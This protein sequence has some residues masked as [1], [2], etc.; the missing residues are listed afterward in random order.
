MIEHVATRHNRLSDAAPLVSAGLV[1]LVAVTVVGIGLE[2][3][4]SN[5][6]TSGY[7]PGSIAISAVYV[8]CVV[9][10]PGYSGR[11]LG[12]RSHWGVRRSLTFAAK[13][14]LALQLLWVPIT[15]AVFSM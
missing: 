1:T 10:I 8:L 11:A 5:V 9:M 7:S 2:I 12:L 4:Y 15:L 3:A 6:Q 14:S 13:L